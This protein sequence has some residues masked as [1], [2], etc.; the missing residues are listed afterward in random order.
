LQITVVKNQQEYFYSL[1]HNLSELFLYLFFYYYHLSKLNCT[2]SSLRE[3]CE[4]KL[5]NKL[6]SLVAIKCSL[7]SVGI[8]AIKGWQLLGTSEKSNYFFKNVNMNLSK[9]QLE[10]AQKSTATR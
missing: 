9:Y 2:M 7:P 10:T 8:R 1:A 4:T 6:Q 5:C 3:R